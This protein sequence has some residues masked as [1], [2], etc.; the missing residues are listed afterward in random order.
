MASPLL[1]TCSWMSLDV[2]RIF[3]RSVHQRNMRF[4]AG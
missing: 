1:L 3:I 4:G 2:G